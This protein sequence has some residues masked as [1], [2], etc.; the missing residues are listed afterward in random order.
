MLLKLENYHHC[1]EEI[2]NYIANLNRDKIS[3]ERRPYHLKNEN[4]LYKERLT[5][6]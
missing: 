5:K 4:N 3:T 2:L 6:E 1:G